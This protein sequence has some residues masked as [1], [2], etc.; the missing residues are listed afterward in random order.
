VHKAV[1]SHMI[2]VLALKAGAVNEVLRLAKEIEPFKSANWSTMNHTKA[3]LT[4]KKKSL[5]NSN[6]FTAFYTVFNLGI[7]A[8]RDVLVG[9][10]IFGNG[11]ALRKIGSMPAGRQQLITEIVKARVSKSTDFTI[12]E[13]DVL[14]KFANTCHEVRAVLATRE[15]QPVIK[16]PMS[17]LV[18]TCQSLMSLGD[19]KKALEFVSTGKLDCICEIVATYLANKEQSNVDAATVKKA[20]IAQKYQS[21]IGGVPNP[22]LAL[23]EKICSHVEA[24]AKQAH[25]FGR[26]NFRYCPWQCHVVRKILASTFAG[27]HSLQMHPGEGKTYVM[28]AA[29]SYA[30]NTSS[31]QIDR[32]VILCLD[33]LLRYQIEAE[34]KR[35]A[36]LPEGKMIIVEAGH[37]FRTFAEFEK[38]RTIFFLDEGDQYLEEKLISYD[39]KGG[40]LDGLI[41]LKD[42]KVFLLSA[43]LG[44][45]WRRVVNQVFKTQDS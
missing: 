10:P 43:T 1:A 6:L 35:M 26:S 21:I 7:Y 9:G 18:D 45:Y 44:D 28:L 20:V 40:E 29:A 39:E 5:P 25:D 13:F 17:K 14:H 11:E 2:F 4:H 8:I 23:Y 37:S 42:H 31:Q 38:K 19:A 36:T 30:L 22:G 16:V 27:V 34:V 41:L 32:V 24:L 3:S 15:F 33:E 12:D